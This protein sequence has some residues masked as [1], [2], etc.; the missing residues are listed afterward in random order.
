MIY[1]AIALIFLWWLVTRT[2]SNEVSSA[3]RDGAWVRICHSKIEELALQTEGEQIFAFS[4]ISVFI[5]TELLHHNSGAFC[6]C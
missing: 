1:K 6:V 3:K 2:P 5:S 4:K